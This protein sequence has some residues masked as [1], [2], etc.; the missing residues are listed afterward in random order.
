MCHINFA[1][2]KAYEDLGDLELAYKHYL[3]G[4]A[5]RKRELQYEPRTEEVFF[6]CLKNTLGIFKK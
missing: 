1:L 2:A 3:E 6:N 5:L 4:N